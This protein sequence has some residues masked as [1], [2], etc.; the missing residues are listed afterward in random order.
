M[1]FSIARVRALVITQFNEFH[2]DFGTVFLSLI[3]PVM[4]VFGL[5]ATNLANPTFEF[6]IGVVDERQERGAQ[7]FVQTLAASPGMKIKSLSRDAMSAALKD[8]DVHAVFVIDDPDFS[9]DNGKV[10]ILVGPRFEAFSRLLLEAVRDRMGRQIDPQTRVFDY[11]VSNPDM[12]V[13]SDLSFTFPG[14]LALAM[15]QL[16]LFA[17]AVPLLQAK[18]RGTLRYLSLTSLTM[19]ELLA[20]QLT[21]RV[22]I[23][24]VQ[25]GLIL[26]AGS[27]ML[28][29][30]LSQWLAVFGISLLGILLL[31]SIG[32]AIAG[33][34]T[35][36]Q[37][38][39]ATILFANFTMLLGGN[40]FMDP[41]GSTAQ[42]VIACVIPISYLADLYRQAISGESGL[43][44]VWLDVLVVL[45]AA[46]VAMAIALRT[47]RFDTD[48]R[49]R[50][51]AVPA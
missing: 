22:A 11:T 41:T 27:T 12:E 3:F 31:V 38:G 4:F 48:M 35:S 42:Y 37:G 45:G 7:E 32:Y 10:Q 51:V 8:G 15:V 23:A 39:T 28:T 44:P 18:D 14:L 33:M 21:V 5:I 26:L 29:I 2:R 43:W 34:A 1:N 36:Q 49:S 40:V 6:K 30:S 24:I 13:R 47:F 9:T 17:T 50:A 20:G 25:V 46:L 19:S 16:G